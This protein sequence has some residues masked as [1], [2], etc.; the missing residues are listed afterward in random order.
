M[1]RVLPRIHSKSV[2]SPTKRDCPCPRCRRRRQLELEAL[3]EGDLNLESEFPVLI[4]RMISASVGRSGTNREDD[5]RSVQLL[6][7]T[8]ILAGRLPSHSMLTVDG[9]ISEKMIAAIEDF[10]KRFV[11]MK[12]PDG[13][14]DPAG[15]T[16]ENLNG[17]VLQPTATASGAPA[18]GRLPYRVVKGQEYGPR[19]RTTR[20]PGLPATARHASA[21][22]DA[23][24]AVRAAAN[25]HGLGAAFTAVVTH[26]AETE[27]GTTFALPANI[28]DARPPAERPSG[29]SLITAWGVFQF[30]RDAW[31]ALPGVASTAFP[32]QVSVADEV[33]RPV[34]RYADLFQQ[35][36]DAGGDDLAGARGI[37]LWHR[38]PAAFRN[39]LRAGARSGFS[40]AWRG[41]AARHRTPVDQ[42][43]AQIGLLANGN[44]DG[45]EREV[46]ATTDTAVTLTGSVGAGGTNRVGDVMAVQRLLNK[47]I[48]SGRLPG[49]APLAADGIIGAKTGAAIRA[50]QRHVV[51]MKNPD[52]LVDP[53]G[54]TLK[55][56][57]GSLGQKPA[58]GGAIPHIPSQLSPAG[59]ACTAQGAN[60]RCDSC[61]AQERRLN[62]APRP[63]LERV[64]SEF[65]YQGKS[66]VRLDS[67]AATAYRDMV[68][69]ARAE[70]VS[71]PFLTIH[72][73]YRD[74]DHQAR[75]WKGRLLDRFRKAGCSATQ[76][77]CIEHAIDRTTGAL[78]SQPMPH[79]REDWLTR[80]LQELRQTAC[81]IVCSPEAHVKALR[82]GTAPPGRSPHHTGRAI[83]IH[84]GGAIS[85]ATSNVAF[86]RRQP[87]FRWLVCN[88]A[89]FGFHP[90]NKEPWHW[91]F[92][93]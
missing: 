31:R 80:F 36:R 13:R 76:L 5:V 73:G 66:G 45:Q 68:R 41:V 29:K 75:L 61:Q 70:G 82:S 25:G 52:G 20:P 22:G 54:R 8:F 64:P 63:T 14:V 19:W 81:G 37:R 40:A 4:T 74:Y 55:A 44:R 28:F 50:F 26:L 72:S 69:A 3:V 42:R 15:K 21:R 18:V 67:T 49:I 88:A 16:L 71:A 56:L 62:R 6:L 43:M 33:D 34:A 60:V 91:E 83:D 59:A 47:F 39:Y 78:R 27:S 32:W 12:N 92:N 53:G 9:K 77:G 46:G 7:N 51:G 58:A 38:S 11:G 10:Q 57:D 87:A 2:R 79:N 89:R 65:G 86:Q 48:V 90:Y 35:I 85:T 1:T 24:D 17:S 84:V 23:R 30:N 93:P